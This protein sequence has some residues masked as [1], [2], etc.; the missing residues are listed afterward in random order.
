MANEVLTSN[1]ERANSVLAAQYLLL[2]ADRAV[3]GQHPAIMQ[4][5]DVQ[6]IN[7]NVIKVRRLGLDGYD[8]MATATEIQDLAN[9]AFTDAST[10]ITVGRYSLSYDASTLSMGTDS[11]LSFDRFAQSLL[12]SALV[13]ETSV[14][15]ALASGFSTSLG[16]ITTEMSLTTFL[17]AISILEIKNVPGPYL[18]VGHGAHRRG[19]RFEQLLA[20]GGQTQYMPPAASAIGSG[21]GGQLF[22]VDTFFT[23]RAPADSTGFEGMM[24]G[25]G[26]ILRGQMTPPI[27]DPSRQRAVGNILIEYARDA[28][29]TISQY[30]GHAYFAYAENDDARGVEI[31]TK[32]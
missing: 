3:M 9:V 10:N 17:S 8:I 25:Q 23:N 12:N 32:G 27:E 6:G 22:G 7:N 19:I 18:F 16:S 4:A 1:L 24:V 31:K 14:C 26:A 29:A 5:G 15:A 21:A 11:V 30:H 2:L 28:G 13:T 20:V